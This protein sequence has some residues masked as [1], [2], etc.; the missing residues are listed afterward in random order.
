MNEEFRFAPRTMPEE[1][2]IS[3]RVLELSSAARRD[4]GAAEIG[5]NGR[6]NGDHE[7]P[8][9][10][11]GQ[12]IVK[13]SSL[14]I[15]GTLKMNIFAQPEVGLNSST[16]FINHLPKNLSFFAPY[17]KLWNKIYSM[18]MIAFLSLFPPTSFT[19]KWS[20]GVVVNYFGSKLY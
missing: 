14:S 10:G 8:L 11:S 17:F 13:I 20:R 6:V 2:H 4:R 16:Y 3:C 9:L 5:C 1:F 15:G 18:G 12:T 19:K 7:C